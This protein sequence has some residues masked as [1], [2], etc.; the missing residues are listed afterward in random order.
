[1]SQEREKLKLKAH[2]EKLKNKRG[3]ERSTYLKMG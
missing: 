3:Q 2:I 1:M